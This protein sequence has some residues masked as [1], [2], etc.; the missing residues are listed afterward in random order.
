MG[1]AEAN[2]LLDTRASSIPRIRERRQEAKI[3]TLAC[4]NTHRWHACLMLKS[5]KPS[6]GS[7]NKKLQQRKNTMEQNVK[8]ADGKEQTGQGRCIWGCIIGNLNIHWARE[9]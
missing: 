3:R 6:T 5:E 8:F 2:D 1:P 9:A 7:L 4:P